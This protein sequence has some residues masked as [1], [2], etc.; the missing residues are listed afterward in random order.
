MRGE[1]MRYRVAAASA[2]ARSAS[3]GRARRLPDDRREC[4][5]GLLEAV[6]DDDARELVLRREL[7]LGGAQARLDL[8]RL[9]GSAADQARAKRFERRRRDEDLDGLGH[10]LAHLARAL[11][12]DLEQD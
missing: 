7:A 12:L 9:V 4:V 6:V 2:G 1:I 11:D 3:A 5:D 8:L 10:R